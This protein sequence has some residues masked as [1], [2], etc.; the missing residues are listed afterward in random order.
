LA[1]Q[2]TRQERGLRLRELRR[3]ILGAQMGEHGRLL[4]RHSGKQTLDETTAPYLSDV[5]AAVGISTASFRTSLDTRTPVKW[6]AR[7]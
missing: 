7:A 2:A 6:F 3:E 4:A 5:A 1:L